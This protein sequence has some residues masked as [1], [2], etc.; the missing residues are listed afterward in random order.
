MNKYNISLLFVLI[1]FSISAQRKADDIIGTW[2]TGGAEPARILI[3]KIN[4]YYVGKIIWLKFP[5][6]GDG[7]KK[8][9]NN[10]IKTFQNRNIIGINLLNGFK[11]NGTNSWTSGTI[12]DPESGK[13]Y[14]CK[15]SMKD[16]KTLEV[17]G[18]VGISLF[19]RTEVWKRVP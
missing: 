1:S 4:N 16:T 8:D 12:Y 14:S 11:N 18:Y 17:R 2:Q 15:I 7:P 6:D 9:R 13:T 5:E 19:G 3:E 10:P